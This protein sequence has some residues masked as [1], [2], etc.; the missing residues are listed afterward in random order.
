PGVPRVRAYAS[1]HEIGQTN[2]RGELLV[3]NLLS[4]YGNRLA[5]DQNDIPFNYSIARLAE[6]VATPYRGG[7][8]VTFPVSRVQTLTGNVLVTTTRGSRVP[9][10]GQFVLT[11]SSRTFESPVG[12][13]G[14]FYFE[15]LQPGRYE[16]RVEYTGGACHLVVEIPASEHP[17]IDVGILHCTPAQRTA[18]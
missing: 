13:Q 10:Y 2:R 8:V 6:T 11:R 3:P 12:S 18:P 9:A 16:G 17:M 1:N 7:A 14:E 4:Y 5:I 15:N